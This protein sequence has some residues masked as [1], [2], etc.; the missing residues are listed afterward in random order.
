MAGF[1]DFPLAPQQAPAQD[2]WAAFPMAQQPAAPSAPAAVAVPPEFAGPSGEDLRIEPAR[3]PRAD[4]VPTPAAPAATPVADQGWMEYLANSLGITADGLTK[5]VTNVAG[6]PVDA[7]NASPML[8]NLLPGDQG[9]GPISDYPIGGSRSL[10]D[11]LDYA[12]DGIYA[13]LTMGGERPDAPTPQDGFQRVLGR[14]AEEIGGAAVPMAGLLGAAA[15]TG[16]QGARELG[17]ISRMFVEPA[18]VNPASFVTKEATAATA[19]GM[20]AGLANEAT[21]NQD[22]SNPWID[23]LGAFGGAGIAST[24]EAVL[25]GMTD[26]GAAATGSTR[27]ANEIVR[28]RVADTLVDNSSALGAQVDAAVPGAPI[29]TDPLVD[30]ITRASRAEELVPGFQASTADRAGDAGLAA[31]ESARARN[32]P[33]AYR[34]RTDANTAA[35][36]GAM[37][38]MAPQETPGAFRE[39]LETQRGAALNDA[40][41]ATDAA[42]TMYNQAIAPLQPTMTA[43]GRGAYMREAL[44]SASDR[45]KAALSELWA[46]INASREAVPAAP[47][48]DAFGGVDAGLGRAET[49]RF[50]PTEADDFT[51]LM[52][53]GDQVALNE[54]T[55]IRSALTDAQ[56]EA[57]ASGRSSE[58]RVIGQYVDALDGAM[59]G[60][61]PDAIRGQYDTA[62]TATRDF[63]D[64]FARDNTAVGQTLRRTDGGGYRASDSSVPRRFVQSDQ[65]DLA[66][67]DA[68]FREAGDNPT[69]TGAFRDQ[70]LQDARD[71]GALDSQGAASDFVR[72][73]SRALDRFPETREGIERAGGARAGLD[74]AQRSKRETMD[75]LTK[76]GRSAVAS[77]LSYG[78]ERAR[79]A[80]R[81]VLKSRDPAA[82]ADELLTFAG[83]EPRA[84]EGARRAFW[85]EMDASSRAKNAAA[86]TESGTMPIVPRKM[87]AFLDDPA[88][89]AVAERLYRDNPQH[90]A[91]VRELAEALRGVG[92]GQRIGN[93]VNPSGTALMMRGQSP[94]TMA[95]LGSKFYQMQ[96]GRVSPAY[97]AA[98]IAGKIA[99][100]S[101]GAQRA[102]AF[103]ALLD[104]ALLDPDTARTLLAENNPA[105]RAALA[106]K[107]NTWRFNEASTVIRM[108]ED[109]EQDETT[110]AIMGDGQ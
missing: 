47:Y 103:D 74:A 8:L 53:E 11:A 17:P 72:D 52:A 24:G 19:A 60:T 41:A 107:L 97:L 68:F 36:E 99:S 45:T 84:V 33:G 69:A 79:D 64:R 50:R 46:P 6:L 12:S 22:R 26:L 100:K 51:A 63:N 95:E 70:V 87:A 61:L 38:G 40:A 35:V 80:I 2:P 42:Q 13:G 76:P 108:L 54:V 85:D 91:D 102:K 39:A 101:V 58:A 71:R 73:N 92:I 49:R 86:E 93:A 78:N 66:S 21:G 43:E 28:Q 96:L 3:P 57:A 25:R 56:R 1:D 109:D 18:A 15:R 82:T 77:Y 20:G 44:Q 110:R 14:T 16:V 30:A 10:Y 62:R 104:R 83:N 27:Y 65:G 9:F 32:N 4:A 7:I 59:E 37:S 106:R 31:L 48:A 67:T 34:A 89:A 88:N 81:S 23:M 98:H 5:G 75:R 90:L 29:N 105:N 55:G 94:V